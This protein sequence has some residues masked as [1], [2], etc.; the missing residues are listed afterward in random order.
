MGFSVLP[1]RALLFAMT[2]D[3]IILAAVQAL[4]GISGAVL[5]VLQALI[6]ADLTNG[7]G[8]F[9]LAQGLVGVAS[10]LGASV[11]TTLFGLIAD[12]LG[13]AAAFLAITL[14]GLLAVVIVW[15]FM[16]ET[17]PFNLTHAS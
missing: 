11:S 6:I 16:P 9:N 1:V 5:G 15:L 8:R 17:K 14:T 10:G 12:S 4:D 7:T 3:P 13:R 2:T